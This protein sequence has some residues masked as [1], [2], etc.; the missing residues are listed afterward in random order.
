LLFLVEFSRYRN[1]RII[2]SNY[3][4]AQTIESTFDPKSR[5]HD[6][7]SVLAGD[8]LEQTG[9]KLDQLTKQLNA[10]RSFQ[11]RRDE[12]NNAKTNRKQYS[13]KEYLTS[14][15]SKAIW[16][17]AI[18]AFILLV[19]AI[20]YFYYSNSK[21][22]LLDISK[23]AYFGNHI[24]STSSQN[25]VSTTSNIITS[26]S[27]PTVIAV[28]TVLGSTISK[29]TTSNEIAL[30][31]FNNNGDE[32]NVIELSI[33]EVSRNPFSINVDKIHKLPSTYIPLDLIPSELP[34]GGKLKREAANLLRKLFE[35][36]E[37]QSIKMK[38]VSAYRSFEDQEIL[39]NYYVQQEIKSG[40][41]TEA[42]A[43]KRANNYSAKPGHSEHQLGT[44]VD[45]NCYECEGLDISVENEKVWK[46][47]DEYG[48]K[49]GFKISY[50]KENVAGYQYEPW[51]I[52]Y[53][54][55]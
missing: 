30:N 54:G 33:E 46:F 9:N 1:K 21:I 28:S 27:E 10:Q 42:D 36:A 41:I 51:H 37:R 40:A 22:S 39:F 29:S 7:H 44:T 14:L 12:I 32:I 17:T 52:R 48:P 16:T 34:G 18:S 47:L 53:H 45:I 38:I 25:I 6:I 55:L 20:I 35:E 31:L 5:F 2:Y 23:I 24:T 19:A 4:F 8:K 43:V 15:P 49:Y 50:T 13:F 3:K 26:N 11:K